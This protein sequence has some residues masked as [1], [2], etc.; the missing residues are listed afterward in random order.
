MSLCLSW[1]VLVYEPWK[2]SDLLESNVLPCQES[3]IGL[4][5]GEK[6]SLIM[7]HRVWFGLVA[8]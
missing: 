7:F 8:M 2:E 3:M 5:V 1:S 6:L 4:E